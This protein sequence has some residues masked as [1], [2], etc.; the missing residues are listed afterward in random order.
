MISSVSFPITDFN[1]SEGILEKITHVNIKNAINKKN[2]D[3][4]VRL[5]FNDL[6]SLKFIKIH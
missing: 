3:F 1:I 4:I 2:D 6:A 5:I